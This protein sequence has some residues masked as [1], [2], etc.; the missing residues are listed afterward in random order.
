[1]NISQLAMPAMGP[2]A[3]WWA[4]DHATGGGL[5]TLFQ[6]VRLLLPNDCNK[7]S[8]FYLYGKGVGLMQLLT[9]TWY[10]YGYRTMVESIRYYRH[11]NPLRYGVAARPPTSWLP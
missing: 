10:H 8:A 1:M 2:A 3:P 9:N 7:K 4:I 5:G 6:A 11:S